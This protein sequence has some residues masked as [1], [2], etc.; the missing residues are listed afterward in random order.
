MK[1]IVKVVPCYTE[2]NENISH[3]ALRRKIWKGLNSEYYQAKS[4]KS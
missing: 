1:T 3:I 2:E 4:V